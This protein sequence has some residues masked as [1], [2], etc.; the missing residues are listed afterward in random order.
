MVEGFLAEAV[1]DENVGLVQSELVLEYVFAIA[2]DVV[3]K[4]V[5]IVVVTDSVDTLISEN[6]FQINNSM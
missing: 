6:V 3:V 1:N 4:A 5:T 2:G